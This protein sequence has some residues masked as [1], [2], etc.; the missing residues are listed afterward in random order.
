MYTVYISDVYMQDVYSHFKL[1]FLNHRLD[2]ANQ[3]GFVTLTNYVT[4]VAALFL[5]LLKNDTW[6][7][8]CKINYSEYRKR[9]RARQ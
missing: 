5:S 7:A 9:R 1:S 2:Y 4:F 8:I 3:T 6:F